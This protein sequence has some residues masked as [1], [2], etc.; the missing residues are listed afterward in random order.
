[1]ALP[2]S[3]SPVLH[4]LPGIVG[5]THVRSLWLSFCNKEPVTNIFAYLR[6]IIAWCTK[7]CVSLPNLTFVFMQIYTV[8]QPA[9]LVWN[10]ADSAA[11]KNICASWPVLK[12]AKIVT[13]AKQVGKG[14]ELVLDYAIDRNLHVGIGAPRCTRVGDAERVPYCVRVERKGLESMLGGVGKSGKKR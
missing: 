4:S 11:V 13:F 12:D 7:Q 8:F 14:K 10:L 2:P 3:F 5:E 1:M 9:K 6:K